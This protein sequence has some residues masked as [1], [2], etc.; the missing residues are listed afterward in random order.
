MPKGFCNLQ[1]QRTVF[2][3]KEKRERITK[4]KAIISVAK[5]KNLHRKFL[6]HFY[7]EI[8]YTFNY[9]IQY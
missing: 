1:D 6:I 4:E 2:F 5:S 8:Q 7:C 9:I 3:N